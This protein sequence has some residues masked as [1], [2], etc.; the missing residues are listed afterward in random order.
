MTDITT[1]TTT[2]IT[3]INDST[4]LMMKIFKVSQQ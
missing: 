4:T 3:T 2:T 1:K